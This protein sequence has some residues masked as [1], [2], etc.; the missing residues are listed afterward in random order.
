M[1]YTRTI[2]ENWGKPESETPRN[3]VIPVFTGGT[4]PSALDTIHESWPVKQ[5]PY[6]AAVASPF[7][8]QPT[9]ESNKPAASLWSQLRPKGEAKIEYH[10]TAEDIIGESAVLLHAPYS[11][12]KAQPSNRKYISSE[13][14]RIQ[15]EPTR[16]FHAKALWLEGENWVGYM[17]GSSN[18]TTAG[19]G[20]GQKPNIEA[21]LLYL[22]DPNNEKAGE[23]LNQAFPASQAIDPNIELRW[24]PVPNEDEFESDPTLLPAAFDAAYLYRDDKCETFIRL[25]LTGEPPN[26]WSLWV[27]DQ[28]EC[29]YHEALW[30]EDGQPMEVTLAWPPK[31]KLPQGFTVCWQGNNGNAW[32]PVNIESSTS[33][34][35]PEELRDLS[36]ELLIEIL[37]S[38]RPLH[39]SLRRRMKHDH[40]GLPYHLEK[41]VI[42][43]HKRIDTSA[44]VLRR[45]RRVAWALRGLR[46]RLEKPVPT[47]QSLHWR[48]YGPVGV[49][50]MANA[51]TKEASS[52]EEQAFMLTELVL[53][54]GRVQ[55]NNIEEYINPYIVRSELT[56]AI[57]RIHKHIPIDSLSAESNFRQYIENAFKH[58]N[59]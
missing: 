21:N 32:L 56:K 12:M 59:V 39:Q 26:N 38:A 54:I 30:F 25:L 18:F 20:L 8:N 14:F 10:V 2:P 29:F 44:F 17:I 53:E 58:V 47:L 5:L 23:A 51:L 52:N 49:V 35:P 27:E 43:P 45:M 55:P 41:P 48:L 9:E 46:E 13:V 57:K 19:M 6:L 1:E 7:F 33:L 11:L 37:T 42:D 31:K 40:Q 34:P 4:R 36:L 15:D 24:E 50:A 3:T 28:S 22:A 16:P